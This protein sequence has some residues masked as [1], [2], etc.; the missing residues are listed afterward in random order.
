ML[1]PFGYLRVHCDTAN[2]SGD[3][4][5]KAEAFLKENGTALPQV[6]GRLGGLEVH[7]TAWAAG[8][9]TNLAGCASLLR[10]RACARRG[11][12]RCPCSLLSAPILLLI[13][14]RRLGCVA[15]SLKVFRFRRCLFGLT[16][17]HDGIDNSSSLGKTRQ[18]DEALRQDPCRVMLCSARGL[19]KLAIPQA[20]SRPSSCWTVGL[21]FEV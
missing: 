19:W 8:G 16:H 3:W 11:P 20:M 2:V 12:C 4:L 10:A 14:C 7:G 18:R 21:F 15:S 13:S 5:S 1:V 6:T 9:W 17:P